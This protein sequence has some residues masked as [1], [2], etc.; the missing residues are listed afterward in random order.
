MPPL[1]PT[2]LFV[3]PYYRFLNDSLT[4]IAALNGAVF[5]ATPLVQNGTH[6]V[7]IATPAS[8]VPAGSFFVES[9]RNQL[10]YQAVAGVW[11]YIAG[12]YRRTQSQL[13][14]LAA[15]LGTGDTGLLVEV[16]DYAH[17]LRWSGTAWTWGPGEA[18]SGMFA[19]FA[20]APTGSGWHLCDGSTGVSY[21][22]ADGTT[23]TLDLPNANATATFVQL[24]PAYSSI[25]TP[26]TVPTAV[27]TKPTITVNNAT[28][29][30]ASVSVTTTTLAVDTQAVHNHTASLDTTPATTVSLPG[31]PVAYFPAPLW[32]RQ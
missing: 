28:L 32:F 15:T 5:G 30:Q 22:K 20:Q 6:A 13:S 27:T 9:D 21:L 12:T 10:L 18:G 7:R 19:A 4:S 17:V 11:T 3:V 16:T 23:G 1:D 2:G 14:A 31:P 29:T 24:G 26:A 8:G 25:I